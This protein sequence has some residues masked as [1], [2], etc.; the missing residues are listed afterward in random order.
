MRLNPA[1]GS[2][3]HEDRHGQQ[4]QRDRQR[5]DDPLKFDPAIEHQVVENS[6]DQHEHRSLR[7]EGGATPRHDRNEVE[8][9]PLLCT[10]R[11]RLGEMDVTGWISGGSRARCGASKSIVKHKA[12]YLLLLLV[13]SKAWLPAKSISRKSLIIKLV[14]H[15]Y[16]TAS[17]KIPLASKCLQFTA[18]R[19]GHLTGVVERLAGE[20]LLVGD[21]PYFLTHHPGE[22]APH[23]T[24]AT[25]G[26]V[27]WYGGKQGA[28]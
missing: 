14:M 4:E 25:V 10:L 15:K 21:Q 9:H 16:A 3:V 24:T 1:M 12:P 6:E 7:K 18:R 17:H 26:L 20:S 27:W 5:A 13:S 2:K 28:W 19:N 22:H 8:I 11:A 23:Q